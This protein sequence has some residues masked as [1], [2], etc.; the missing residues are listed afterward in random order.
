MK[1]PPFPATVSDDGSSE[2]P[3]T[4]IDAET[5]AEVGE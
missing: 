3:E 2:N 4:T 5:T 1:F